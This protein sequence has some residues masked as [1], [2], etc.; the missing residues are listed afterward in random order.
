[1]NTAVSVTDTAPLSVP[2]ARV[3]IAAS[4][5]VLLLLAG[6]HVLS[7]EFDPSFRGE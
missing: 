6:L 7:P 3:A 5:A 4:G 1:M 2:A